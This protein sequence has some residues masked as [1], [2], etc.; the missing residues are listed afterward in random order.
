MAGMMTG[1]AVSPRASSKEDE[2]RRMMQIMNQ[3]V[4]PRASS[5]KEDE[6]SRMMQMM[7]LMQQRRAPNAAIA[8]TPQAQQQMQNFQA[9]RQQAVQPL[10]SVSGGSGTAKPEAPGLL[11][12]IARRTMDVMQD[13]VANAQLVSALNSLRFEPDQQLGKVMQA[14]A[15]GVQERRQGFQDTEAALGLLKQR[16]VLDNYSPQQIEQLRNSPRLV[17]AL[18]EAAM[19]EPKAPSTFQQKVDALV[20]TGITRAQAIRQVI[21]GEAA[22]T[23]INMPD[24]ARA[25]I[26]KATFESDTAMQNAARTALDTINKSNETLSLLERGNLNL[27][28]ANPVLQFKDRLLSLT[29]N[30]EA[31]ARASDTDLLNSMLGTDVFGAIKSLGIGARGLDTP[32]EREFLREVLT[33]TTSMEPKTIE[34]M[35]RLR[36]KYARKAIDRYNAAVDAGQFSYIEEAMNRP[37][38]SRFSKI[39]APP[40]IDLTPV[41]RPAGYPEED[42]A[43]VPQQRRQQAR[44]EWLRRG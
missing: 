6:E 32:Q 9:A 11:S 36:A 41:E 44:D 19:K 3:A 38:G 20:S 16:G 1:Q 31:A 7:E 2:E 5:S 33:G 13:P 17:M 27:G 15:A 21:E 8:M 43:R 28:L 18:A 12:R 35:A 30:V 39:E 29:G 42:W 26:Y 10:Q 37:S 24:P 14:R 25:T 22:G 40:L 23:N 4:S 34:K